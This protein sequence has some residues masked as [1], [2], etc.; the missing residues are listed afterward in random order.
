MVERGGDQLAIFDT[1]ATNFPDRRL[2]VRVLDD[3]TE[4]GRPL[5]ML[6]IAQP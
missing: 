4:R 3:L 5:E 1:E 2:P 6:V